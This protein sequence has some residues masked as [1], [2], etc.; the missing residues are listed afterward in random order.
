MH[1]NL[2]DFL[3]IPLFSGCFSHLLLDCLAA[4]ASS[5]LAAL[6]WIFYSF[7]LLSASLAGFAWLAALATWL[8]FCFLCIVFFFSALLWPA[9]LKGLRVFRVYML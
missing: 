2:A 8:Q 5:C 1:L 4:L 3:S 9:F 7:A 6:A